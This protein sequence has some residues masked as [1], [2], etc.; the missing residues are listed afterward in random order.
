M[1]F[2]YL[3]FICIIVFYFLSPSYFKTSLVESTQVRAIYLVSQKVQA[4]RDFLL[5]NIK[6]TER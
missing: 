2:A 3:A 5:F 4:V 6:T 1:L